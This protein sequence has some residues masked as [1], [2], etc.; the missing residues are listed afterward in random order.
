MKRRL[1][2]ILIALPIIYTVALGIQV[3][4]TA[5]HT[6]SYVSSLSGE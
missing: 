4:L 2:R 6:K 5:M 1:I 3:G